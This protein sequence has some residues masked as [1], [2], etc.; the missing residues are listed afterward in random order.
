MTTSASPRSRASSLRA[1]RHACGVR[2]PPRRGLGRPKARRRRP[3]AAAQAEELRFGA[4]AISRASRTV[5]LGGQRVDLT[6]AEFDLLWLLA[7]RAGET[8]S[9]DDIF[10]ATR[11]LEYDGLDRSVDM[12]VSRLRKL[13]GDDA[14]P[15]RLIRTVRGKGYL[16]S[17]IDW[18]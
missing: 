5:L 1:S 6:T 12:R 18:P 14:D 10:R 16:F 4:L 17:K 8:L 2:T 13:L 7:A 3:A 15:A 9:R 11:G